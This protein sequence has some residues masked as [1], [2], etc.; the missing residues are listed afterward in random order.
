MFDSCLV[1]VIVAGKS[2]EGERDYGE[3]ALTTPTFQRSHFRCGVVR[4]VLVSVKVQGA[5]RMCFS[6]R[7]KSCLHDRQKPI[8]TQPT[9][10]TDSVYGCFVMARIAF[11]KSKSLASIK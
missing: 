8:C 9:K 2:L 5:K 6:E 7:Q 4:M 10:I 3:Q 11:H 1:S